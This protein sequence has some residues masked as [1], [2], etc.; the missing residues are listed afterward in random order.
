MPPRAGSSVY[1]QRQLNPQNTVTQNT[2]G[3]IIGLEFL[4]NLADLS[5]YKRGIVAYLYRIH[6]DGIT[7]TTENGVL[8]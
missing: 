7:L 2:T 1:L 8:L 3:D 4:S 6:A 5:H